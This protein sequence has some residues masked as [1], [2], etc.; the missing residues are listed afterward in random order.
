MSYCFALRSSNW[1]QAG[2]FQVTLVIFAEHT[3]EDLNAVLDRERICLAKRVAPR[4]QSDELTLIQTINYALRH[5]APRRIVGTKKEST[6]L[7]FMIRL[8]SA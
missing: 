4:A 2:E 3:G 1:S 5:N 8:P 7:V 6:E